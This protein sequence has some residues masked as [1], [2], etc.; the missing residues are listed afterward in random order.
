MVLYFN[1]SGRD[2]AEVRKEEVAVGWIELHSVN[3]L[4]CNPPTNA[5]PLVPSSTKVTETLRG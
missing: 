4:I 1:G 5:P 3:R 2:S